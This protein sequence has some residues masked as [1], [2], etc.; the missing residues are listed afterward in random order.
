MKTTLLDMEDSIPSKV[1]AKVECYLCDL[2]YHAGVSAEIAKGIV[3]HMISIFN[4]TN[5]YKKW[6]IDKSLER[7]LEDYLEPDGIIPDIYPEYLEWHNPSVVSHEV[8][9]EK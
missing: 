6:Q 9:F 5:A 7:L 2:G 8:L 3:D 4:T 1:L